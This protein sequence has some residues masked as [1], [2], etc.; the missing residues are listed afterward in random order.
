MHLNIKN[1]Q[2][3]TAL[4]S[5]AALAYLIYTCAFQRNFLSKTYLALTLLIF[6]AGSLAFYFINHKVLVPFL[7]SLKVSTRRG[8]VI[9]ALLISA[10]LLLNFDPQ[11]LY[12]LLPNHSL[13][14][15]LPAQPGA[16]VVHFESLENSLGYIAYAK[17]N[18]QGNWSEQG[19][20]LQIQPDADFSLEWQG[21]AGRLLQVVF[22]PTRE[23]RRVDIWLDGQHSSLELQN[24]NGF[25]VSFRKDFPIS[26]G[27]LL[28]TALAFLWITT[29]GLLMMWALLDKLSIQEEKSKPAKA[30]WLWYAL[31]S[32]IVWGLSLLVFWPGMLSNDSL[33]QWGQAL[34]GQMGDWHPIFHTFL[35][36]VLM[37]I[38]YSP[39]LPAQLQILALALVFARGLG[40][41]QEYG[42]PR[43]I[44]W[45]VAV[46]FAIFP[47][48][49]LF[50]ITLWKDVPYA[51]A[52]L[53]LFILFLRIALTSGAWL[54]QKRSWLWLGL[55]GFAVASFR[56]NGPAVAFLSILGLVF[57]F[58]SY[59][60]IILRGLALALLTWIG[61][62]GMLN[63]A[64]NPES[65]NSSQANL[66]L[67]SHIAAHVEAGTELDIEQSAYLNS[68]MP[69]A[70]WESDCCYIGGLSY[71][72]QFDRQTY[73]ENFP[74]NLRL[75]VNLFLR[76]PLVDVRQQLCASEMNWVFCD[77]RCSLKSLHAFNDVT[78]GEESWILPNDY[79]LAESSKLPGLVTPLVGIL[80]NLGFFSGQT[81]ALLKPALYFY[82]ALV[83]IITACLRRRDG[84]LA[85]LLLPVLLQTGILAVII[86][87]PSF[88]YQYGICLIG[89]FSLALPFLPKSK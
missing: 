60:R 53:A 77:N 82:L 79:G 83:L 45:P 44:L 23:E 37:R 57:F 84:R 78:P 5:G 48:N 22:Q 67:L 61:V 59:W 85:V 4:L 8:L 68:L 39:A 65:G 12:A 46:L 21:K 42:T 31:P 41:L 72:P 17:L 66:I 56:Q 47:F 73:L 87:A 49:A 30:Q 24:D 62:K 9:A 2:I 6:I 51:I 14:V 86:F 55:A 63:W 76:A 52:L 7:Q 50:S 54:A 36:S 20:A 88:R 18:P 43:W 29:Y 58:K 10:L 15:M 3:I 64:Y 32:I 81:G 34:S 28:P 35:L 19:I 1:R 11:P 27:Q 71:N 33:G 75:T 40:L 13:R 25:A 74:G 89:L 38:W 26:V 70:D 80:A 69:L 16:S